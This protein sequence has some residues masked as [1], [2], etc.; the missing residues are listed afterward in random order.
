MKNMFD[1]KFD[2]FFY[3]QISQVSL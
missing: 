1:Y 2:G 3:I